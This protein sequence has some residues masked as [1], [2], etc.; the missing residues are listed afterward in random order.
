MRATLTLDRTMNAEDT[1]LKAKEWI[2]A[3]QLVAFPD[4]DLMCDVEVL[5]ASKDFRIAE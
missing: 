5:K 3:A 4:Q 2:A 1:V